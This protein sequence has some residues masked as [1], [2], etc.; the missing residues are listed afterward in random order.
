LGSGA[1]T[2]AVCLAPF[3]LWAIGPIQAYS[4]AA[5]IAVVLTAVAWAVCVQ[6]SPRRP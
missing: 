2:G 4:A 1:A 5:W 3:V 6:Q